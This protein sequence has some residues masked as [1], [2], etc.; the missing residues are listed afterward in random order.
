MRITPDCSSG[1][2]V[3]CAPTCD[4][5]PG[6]QPVLLSAEDA[7]ASYIQ[8]GAL[9]VSRA[10]VFWL[11]TEPA[12]GI[13][14]LWH[15]TD[16]GPARLGPQGLSIRSR[17]NG[18]GGGAL[19]ASDLG[20]FVVSEDQQI[21]FIDRMD[22]HC[23]QL[24][25][26]RGVA[27]GGLVA[28]PTRH[29]VLAVRER[30]GQQQ[31]VAVGPEQGI[32][33]LH[34]GQDFYGAPALSD[35]GCH[36]AWVSWQ[37]PDMPWL[38]SELWTAVVTESGWLRG[39]ET[40][41]T[42]SEASVQQPVFAG[43]TL[44]ILSDHG[45]WWQPW[46][47]DPDGIN[48]DWVTCDV[49]HLDHA[50]APWQLGESHHVSLVGGG[51]ARVRYCNGTGELWLLDQDGRQGRR[52]APTFSD[53]RDLCSVGAELYCIAR[54]SRRLDAVLAIN[55]G[56]DQVRVV[57][58]GEEAMK[59]NSPALPQNFV[60]PA[61]SASEPGIQGFFYSPTSAEPENPP[62]LILVAHGGPTSAAYPVFNPHIQFWCQRGFAVAEVNYRGS[63]GFGRQFRL[64]LAGRWGEADV[65]DME[66]AADYLAEC[67]LV[68]GRRLFIQGRSS[69][70]YTVLMTLIAS[71]R[72]AAG[73]S[74]YGVTDPL[75]L[76][77]ATHR[78]ESGY[79]DWLLGS[80][81][82]HPER[83]HARTPLH[84]AGRIR[85]P[86]IFFQGGQ[87]Q[88]VVPEQTRAMIAMMQAAGL[89]PEL[90]WFD[91]EGHGF[92][93]RTSQITLLERLL[94]FYQRASFS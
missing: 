29:R 80:P 66:R 59:G 73:A 65:E 47:L 41:P 19:A 43:D 56:T 53:F 81:H 69:G 89:S 21:H 92:R 5:D 78:F 61:G 67:G 32:Q 38:R 24:T 11:Q 16:Q 71:R 46:R 50:N 35:D 75:R 60:V 1:A 23:Q 7:C 31:L 62:P 82:Q 26:E 37:L 18:Y 77:A 88:V 64:A 8:R 9:S 4:S 30:D 93:Q 91:D 33:I 36:I 2:D 12:L 79:L 27:Y 25:E 13:T 70:G 20:V 40:W 14:A 63:S 57:A 86:M 87:D 76:R 6:R 44:R 48:G 22:G 54:S 45:G 51:W 49:P 85:T 39:C 10:G 58:G 34:C 55:P 94:D 17:V 52:L 84:Q 90:H 15:L 42:P 83:W 74:M 68:D 28:D 3:S 72:F